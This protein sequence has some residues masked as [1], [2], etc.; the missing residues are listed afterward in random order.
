[1]RAFY[2]L[3]FVVI[4]IALVASLVV[5]L[6]VKSPSKWKYWGLGIGIYAVLSVIMLSSLHSSILGYEDEKHAYQK[7]ANIGCN[8]TDAKCQENLL[9]DCNHMMLSNSTA[10]FERFGELRKQNP[11]QTLAFCNEIANK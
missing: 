4:V 7:K 6:V 5:L 8:S 10:D 3:L 1:M 2:A 11:S 9:D